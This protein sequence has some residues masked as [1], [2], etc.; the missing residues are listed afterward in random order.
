M[1]EG[2]KVPSYFDEI[3]YTEYLTSTAGPRK[4]IDYSKGSTA[5]M[6]IDLD[7]EEETT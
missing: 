2:G 3:Q 4:R 7:D 6:A 5:D 1:Q